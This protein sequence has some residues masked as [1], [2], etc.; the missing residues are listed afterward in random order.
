[1]THE[2]SP[3]LRLRPVLLEAALK[4]LLVLWLA[5]VRLRVVRVVAAWRGCRSRCRTV[6]VVRCWDDGVGL[7]LP[8]GGVDGGGGEE[9]EGYGAELH[10][11]L[12]ML[13]K[14]VV[15]LVGLVGWMCE[16]VVVDELMVVMMS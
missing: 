10:F 15:G 4:T 11:G 13:L 8:P 14:W 5:R 9:S 3:T 16:V 1:M 12:M 7:G 6:G 2:S